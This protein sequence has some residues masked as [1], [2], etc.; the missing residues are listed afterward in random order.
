MI[1]IKNYTSQD[2]AVFD[3]ESDEWTHVRHDVN[4]S[5]SHIYPRENVLEIT[6]KKVV[7]ADRKATRM[8]ENTFKDII[9]LLNKWKEEGHEDWACEF[10]EKMIDERVNELENIIILRKIDCHFFYT[11]RTQLYKGDEHV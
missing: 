8:K 2:I 10:V 9:G 4:A 1:K 5:L 6:D 11:K 3:E 7:I